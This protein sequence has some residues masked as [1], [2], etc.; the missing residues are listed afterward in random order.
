M[1][2]NYIEKRPTPDE[3]NMLTEAVGWG[4]REEQIG[5]VARPTDDFGAGMI[6]YDKEE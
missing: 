5:F 2:I 1:Q 3:L 6:L 4:R